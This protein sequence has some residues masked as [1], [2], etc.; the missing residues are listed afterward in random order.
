MSTPAFRFRIAVPDDVP[1]LLAIYAPYVEK[2]AISFEYEVPSVEEFRSRMETI[3]QR[4]PYLVAEDEAGQI[5]GYAYT[6][7]FIAREAYDRCAETT[8]YL[9]LDARRHGLGKRLY[10]AIEDL[11]RAQG[12]CNLYACIGEPQG[13][14][15]EY[16]TDNSIRFHE[17]L[18]F[19]RIGVFRRC[20]YKFGRWYDMSWAEK[21]LGEPPEAPEPF[22]PFP[23]LDR[24]LVAEILRRAA[25]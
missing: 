3:S 6:H 16:L 15:D 4:Y 13:A 25:E 23:Q 10:R 24:T 2:T 5:L 20:G 1:A 21:L 9:A 14:D 7:T 17:H 22:L 19:R 11:S 12:I 18:G 8:I